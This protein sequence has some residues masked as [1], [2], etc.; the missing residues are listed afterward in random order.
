MHCG[1]HSHS[2]LVN[3][4]LD[5]FIQPV[6]EAQCKEI[7]NEKTWRGFGGHLVTQIAMN[8]TTISSITISGSLEQDGTCYGEKYTGSHSWLNVVVQAIVII[9]VE[10]YLARVK[11]EQNEVSLK[12]GITCDHTA[13]SCLAVEIGETYWSPLTPQVCDKHFLL[14][15]ENG[16]VIIE[17]QAS[18]LITKYLVV[19]DEEQIFALKTSGTRGVHSFPARTFTKLASK[20]VQSKRRFNSIHEH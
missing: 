14:Y 4:G 1:M 13:R 2:S 6:G 19:E 20:P 16:S 18:G 12:S 10:D 17:T 3:K 15:Q 5:S 11:L 8:S 9:Q 7:Q